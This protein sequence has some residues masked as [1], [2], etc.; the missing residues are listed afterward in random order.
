MAV[1]KLNHKVLIKF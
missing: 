1:E